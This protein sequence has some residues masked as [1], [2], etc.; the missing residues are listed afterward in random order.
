MESISSWVG[1]DF[2][3]YFVL[4]GRMSGGKS[5]LHAPFWNLSRRPTVW[6]SVVH[7]PCRNLSGISLIN[8]LLESVLSFVG[9]GVSLTRPVLVGV[10]SRV[11]GEFLLHAP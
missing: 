2:V 11:G 3:P 10:S 5:V 9:R 8:H 7:A 6:E 1:G 4:S